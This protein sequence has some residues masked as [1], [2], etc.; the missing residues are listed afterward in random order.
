M[1]PNDLKQ[2]DLDQI[3]AS[4]KTSPEPEI[5]AA[6][7]DRVWQKLQAERGAA[8][9]GLCASFEP[10]LMGYRSGTLSD[11][12]RMLLDDHLSS[13]IACR[14]K[15]MGEPEPRKV[16]R[17][18][19][20]PRPMIRRVMMIAAAAAV[21][22]GLG[23]ALP[24][25]LNRAL[26][27]NGPRGTVAAIEGTLLTVS[28][29]G[30][31]PLMVGAGIDENQEIRTGRD[32][33]AVIRLRDGST[34]EMAER[35]ELNLTERWLGRTIHLNRGDILV[36][37]ANQGK[38][39]L[40]V[41]T[42]DFLISVKGTIFGVSQGL[43]GSRVSVVEGEVQIEYAG[44]TT[45]LH[46]GEQSTSHSELAPT[47][48]E[49][50][51]A[52]S[53]NF[54][55]YSA[56]LADLRPKEIPAVGSTDAHDGGSLL[57]HLPADA[58]MVVS[59]PNLSQALA[60]AKQNFEDRAKTSP[61][62]AAWLNSSRSQE[63]HL[64]VERVR[65]IGEFLGDEILIAGSGKGWPIA[66]AEL[67]DPARELALRELLEQPGPNRSYAI[68]GSLVV[69]GADT[70]SPAGEFAKGAFGAKV[71][72]AYHK[73]KG[74]LFAANLEQMS[75]HAVLTNVANARPSTITSPT[76]VGGTD[77]GV[78]GL[79]FMIAERT[80]ASP[81]SV[82]SSSMT[83]HGDFHGLSKWL[84][85]PGPIGSLEFVSAQASFAAA[86]ATRNPRDLLSQLLGMV[87]PNAP[88][89]L[90]MFRTRT[91]MD[92]L[93]DFAGTLGGEA[94]I[95]VDGAILPFPDWK[96]V[97]EVEK[98]ANLQA[99]IEKLVQRLAT[100]DAALNPAS[101]PKLTDEMVGNRKFYTLALT[102]P[103][104]TIH[105]TFIDGYMLA[106]A[107]RNLLLT[108][109]SNR[110]A[111]LTLPHASEFRS[112]LPTDTH[113][114]VSG[115]L[116]YNFGPVVGPFADQISATGLLPAD[117][118]SRIRT[119]TENRNPGVVYLY[120]AADHITVGSR[121]NLLNLG[122]STLGGLASGNL[123]SAIPLFGSGFP[124][125]NA[126]GAPAEQ[127]TQ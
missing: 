21:T 107:N 101:A 13:C 7:R 121:G 2:S 125:Q 73:G 9:L 81:G 11:A 69:L 77:A 102:V 118:Q 72:E 109:I 39:K 20:R 91:G 52:W 106:G 60:D 16:L 99:S 49:S 64:A 8:G 93:E 85:A 96:L 67:R 23:F 10:D 83:L 44:V 74:Q 17:M 123:A 15:V 95:A 45:L 30:T 28:A 127:P 53:R 126:T 70:I 78:K 97:L 112:Q 104:I 119:F 100:E 90:E 75:A 41:A 59:F 89:F 29:T 86:F 32:S 57:D 12:R 84:A 71:A 92:P 54:A 43:K 113:G 40:E 61:E 38:G 110:A 87:S 76:N 31:E 19:N 114:N 5:V 25:V 120:G 37:A 65:Q 1:K 105:Y 66:L 58:V 68:E 27:P 26:A 50:E 94:T 22:V 4:V 18:P 80:A 33:H 63:M 36:E 98:P 108:A 117:Q 14:H 24:P 115:I 55:R 6:S 48:V 34:V 82:D 51:L 124:H 88:Q 62:L 122:M 47:S 103:A 46:R 116:Y 56:L 3:V 111:G 35:S 79:R 42:P